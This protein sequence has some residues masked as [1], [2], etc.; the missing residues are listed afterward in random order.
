MS[1]RTEVAKSKTTKKIVEKGKE[2]TSKDGT[3]TAKSAEPKTSKKP[4]SKAKSSTGISSS[5]EIISF[6]DA[7]KVLTKDLSLLLN[8]EDISNEKKRRVFVDTN[9][10]NY[11]LCINTW[12]MLVETVS[13]NASYALRVRITQKGLIDSIKFYLGVSDSIIHD[14]IESSWDADAFGVVSWLLQDTT[15]LDLI[16]QL[17]R[18]PKKLSLK[19]ASLVD[20]NSLSDF[21][22]V[23]ADC[24]LQN[25]REYPYWLIQ[26][27]KEKIAKMLRYYKYDEACGYFSSGTTADAGRILS[28]KVN[29]Y[30]CD[31]P[32]IYDK[33]FVLPLVPEYSDI[34]RFHDTLRRRTA[35]EVKAVPK[36]YKASRIIAEEP[37]VNQFRML[38]IAKSLRTAMQKSRYDRYC[39]TTN[40]D[41][42]REL[43]RIASIDGSYATI[44]KSHASDSV[45]DTLVSSIFPPLI[46]RQFEECRSIY[47]TD[48]KSRRIMQMFATSGSGL[49]FDVESIV[50]TALAL[51]AGDYYH[52][53]TGEKVL[54]PSVFGDDVI[55]DDKV[56]ETYIDFC[57]LLGFTVNAEKS[58]IHLQTDGYYRES[59]GVEYY[60]GIDVASRFYPRKPLLLNE[61]KSLASIVS[62]QKR[63][64]S[65]FKVNLFLRDIIL[66]LEPRMTSHTVGTDCDDM[67]TEEPVYRDSDKGHLHLTLSTRPARKVTEAQR[68]TLEYRVLEHYYYYNFLV[69]GPKYADDLS[70]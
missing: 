26:A 8:P 25:Q 21:F 51:V 46:V 32:Y 53:Y 62:L 54:G 70:R 69:N 19:G 17:L 20:A 37:A 11:Y 66:R 30:A 60:N 55:I 68:Q 4:S 16:L 58:F 13:E 29:Q 52:L 49:T 67:W 35:V 45:T 22:S 36:S 44:D 24:K 38:A 3:L 9:A 33:S 43:C 14:S 39:D 27:L 1:R 40:Q 56:A 41:R 63:L 7:T 34:P 18:Y 10:F 64:Y 47:V 65:S 59:C 12:L 61:A 28:D 5:L 42:N 50:F 6:Q 31:M 48:G 23:N 57:G 2:K 15:D